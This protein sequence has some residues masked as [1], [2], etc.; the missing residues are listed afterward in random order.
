MTCMLGKFYVSNPVLRK[1]SYFE[2]D[3]V[4]MNDL[5]RESLRIKSA[6]SS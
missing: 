4:F 6:V 2:R 5:K 3:I 1:C